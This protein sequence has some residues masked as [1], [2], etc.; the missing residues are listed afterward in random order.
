[1]STDVRHKLYLFIPLIFIDAGVEALLSIQSEL[2]SLCMSVPEE[3]SHD[4]ME[5]IQHHCHIIM[6]KK[7]KIKRKL[8][9]VR[10]QL[11]EQQSRVRR[12]Q[13]TCMW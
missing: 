13:G 12:L 5:R 4:L 9:E 2:A 1:M 8:E 6:W 3:S 11:S 7:H 10:Q